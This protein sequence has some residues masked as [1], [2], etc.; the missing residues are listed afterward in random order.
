MECFI[1]G[2]SEVDCDEG[3]KFFAIGKT[4]F[5]VCAGCLLYSDPKRDFEDV[6]DLIK[7]WQAIKK[8]FK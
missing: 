1:C 5:I 8:K 6:K 2:C 7:V 3:C 4:K